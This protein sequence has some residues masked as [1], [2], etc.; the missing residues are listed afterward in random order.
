MGSGLFKISLNFPFI[1]TYNL[2]Y[3]TSKSATIIKSELAENIRKY[4]KDEINEHLQKDINK[5]PEYKIK[6]LY[7]FLEY[8]CD[9]LDM[10]DQHIWLIKR[11]MSNSMSHATDL[12]QSLTFLEQN[13]ND[14]EITEETKE[15]L[16]NIKNQ[17]KS[18][19]LS[20]CEMREYL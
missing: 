8:A 20:A 6:N 5:M 11:V 13:L 12:Q 14:I 7:N 15:N 1:S 18:L 3:Y 2:P 9:K 19:R 4:L 16:N 10:A 17:L